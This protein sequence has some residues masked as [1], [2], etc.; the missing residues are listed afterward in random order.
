MFRATRGLSCVCDIW[1]I[2]SHITFE[3]GAWYDEMY[4]IFQKYECVVSRIQST[5][6]VKGMVTNDNLAISALEAAL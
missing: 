6:R 4:T 5:D 2:Y 1:I 3:H